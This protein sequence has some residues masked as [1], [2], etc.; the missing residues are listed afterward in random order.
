MGEVGVER[1]TY[2]HDTCEDAGYPR[3]NG[4]H[5]PDGSMGETCSAY[6]VE[7]E[8]STAFSDGAVAEMAHDDLMLSELSRVKDKCM[9]LM[10]R[11][12]LHE[13][14]LRYLQKWL[15]G[16]Q[17]RQTA[18]YF[19][20]HPLLRFLIDSRQVASHPSTLTEHATYSEPSHTPVAGKTQICW[21]P[22]DARQSYTFMLFPSRSRYAES[23]SWLWRR[24]MDVASFLLI[25]GIH[26]TS[27]NIQ[28][29]YSDRATIVPNASSLAHLRM[30]FASVRPSPFGRRR[31][32]THLS[33]DDRQHNKN[34][35]LTIC[36][37][38]HHT[39]FNITHLPTLFPFLIQSFSQGA[40]CTTCR[41]TNG[42]ALFSMRS[43]SLG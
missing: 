27:K 1:D 4:R 5:D 15:L 40:I 29:Y 16:V 10:R 6:M 36:V 3:H 31:Y 23:S 26:T 18:K 21:V 2:F 24:F 42:K 35:Y 11:S 28:N 33:S 38:P 43:P 30:I 22:C 17:I 37:Y 12:V 14:C 32:R 13:L 20:R 19:E 7:G 25:T 41:C 34:T 39:L 8:R 9:V